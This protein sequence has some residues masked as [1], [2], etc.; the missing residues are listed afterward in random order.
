MNYLIKFRVKRE[1]RLLLRYNNTQEIGHSSL[2]KIANCYYILLQ[3]AAILQFPKNINVQL[4]YQ[5]LQDC[6]SHSFVEEY[7]LN[8]A[9]SEVTQSIK[10]LQ[11]EHNSVLENNSR[12]TDCAGV[13][14]YRSFESLVDIFAILNYTADSFSDGGKF[15]KTDSALRQIEHLCSQGAAIIDLGVESTRPG[16]AV[17]DADAEIELLKR[18]LPRV[19]ELK[20]E[21]GFELSID[22]YHPETVLWLNDFAVDIINDVS[23]NL[24]LEVVKPILNSG[25][26]Y[27]AMH[28][29][30]I[31]ADPKVVLHI[32]DNPIDH[33][34]TWLNNKVE[35]ITAGGCDTSNLILD[36]GM[37]FGLNI[38]QSWFVAR[39]IKKL[40][41]LPCEI[42]FGHSRKAFFKHITSNPA[43]DRDLETAVV[44]AKT[45]PYVDYLRLHDL[46]HFNR[47]TPV[48]NQM[49]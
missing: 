28:S 46:E 49:S 7:L 22:T 20:P 10:Y 19:L 34:C 17:M 43:A 31:P 45:S 48:F 23:G 15:N 12:V 27:V 38:A 41:Y 25:K 26:R 9:H 47:I 4:I 6:Y 1:L 35:T 13:L 30:S 2:Y 11:F 32:E 21:L 42:L 16:A 5:D 3:A 39:H 40:R 36:P 14:I 37:G 44:A 29:L 18:V 33:I 24:L 8:W